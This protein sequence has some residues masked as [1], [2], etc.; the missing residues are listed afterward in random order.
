LRQR[1]CGYG[2]PHPEHTYEHS[3][4]KDAAG[5]PSIKLFFNAG[6]EIQYE[7][8]G[9]DAETGVPEPDI[10]KDTGPVARP[11]VDKR[12]SVRYKELVQFYE[13]SWNRRFNRNDYA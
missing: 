9:Y 1:Y 3:P 2:L 8:P 12:A 13:N 11:E 7:C 6:I 5:S 10:S 4:N